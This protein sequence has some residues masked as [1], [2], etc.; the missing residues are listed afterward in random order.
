VAPH[1][2]TPGCLMFDPSAVEI[3]AK[4]DFSVGSH[5]PKQPR[6]LHVRR[7]PF[8]NAKKAS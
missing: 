6:P 8:L 7:A 4:L 3:A 2:S 5:P 1:V